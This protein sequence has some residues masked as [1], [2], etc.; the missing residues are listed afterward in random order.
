MDC[1]KTIGNS[2]NKTCSI[3][4]ADYEEFDIE[5]QEWT[6]ELTEDDI[7]EMMENN[8]DALIDMVDIDKVVEQA[9]IADGLIHLLRVEGFYY[10]DD[11]SG[12]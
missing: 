9:I 6:T 10:E 7:I 12:A 4:R 5:V 2:N 3:C 11:H 1:F 8:D